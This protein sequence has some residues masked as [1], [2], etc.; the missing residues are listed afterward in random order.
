MYWVDPEQVQQD[1]PE[2][3]DELSTVV[4]GNSGRNSIVRDPTRE[5]CSRAGSETEAAMGRWERA[6]DV[7]MYVFKLEAGLGS[8]WAV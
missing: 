3:Q 8:R 2:L 7:H 5:E 6:N 4:R 1:S